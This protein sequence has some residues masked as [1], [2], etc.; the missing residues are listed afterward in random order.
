MGDKRGNEG[1]KARDLPDNQ[2][3]VED[4]GSYYSSQDQARNK[5]EN[6]VAPWEG[7]DGQANVLGKEQGRRLDGSGI[8]AIGSETID[9][10][11]PCAN[12]SSDT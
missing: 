4:H 12:C 2:G 8:R 5:T 1:M 11:V 6:G 7:H 10:I 3:R 9:G